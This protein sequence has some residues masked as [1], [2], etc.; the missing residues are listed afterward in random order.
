MRGMSAVRCLGTHATEVIDTNKDKGEEC[1]CGRQG[2]CHNYG[3]LDYL[4]GFEI[5]FF[6]HQFL[7]PPLISL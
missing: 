4:V 3:M 2:L 5:L 1:R 7:L 6:F